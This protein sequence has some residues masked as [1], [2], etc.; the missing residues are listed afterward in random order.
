VIETAGHRL[1]GAF[2]VIPILDHE[3]ER[4][5]GQVET[6]LALVGRPASHGIDE[7]DGIARYRPTHRPGLDRLTRSIGDLNG[8]LG[9]AEAVADRD[10]P[11]P[12]DFLDDLRIERLASADDLAGRRA[13]LA[14]V[15]LDQ[16]PPYGRR[17]AEARHL[18]AVHLC[19]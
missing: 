8:R 13:Q 15:G 3:A 11:G 5:P 19:H 6:D 7:L 4:P 1:R 2:R 18:A 9:L 12:A 17:A 16:H 14:E 10:A